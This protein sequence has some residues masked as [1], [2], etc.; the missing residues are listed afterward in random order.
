MEWSGDRQLLESP[1]ISK[2]IG[3]RKTGQWSDCPA[4]PR[5]LNAKPGLS[6]PSHSMCLQ[7]CLRYCR[8]VPLRIVT[9]RSRHC[10]LRGN[11]QKPEKTG[12]NRKN[13]WKQ[14]F[15]L[16]TKPRKSRKVNGGGFSQTRINTGLPASGMRR[17]K[18]LQRR[19]GI[20]RLARNET[21]G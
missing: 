7:Y 21:G 2:S 6:V 19:D 13:L 14:G 1:A 10:F 15:L 12:K 5:V 8:D 3:I 20:I 11:G 18:T 4:Q 16:L 9:V 17:G